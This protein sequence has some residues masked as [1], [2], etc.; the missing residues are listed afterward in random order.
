M[1]HIIEG[2]KETL[3]ECEFKR[4]IYSSR[5]FESYREKLAEDIFNYVLSELEINAE[6]LRDSEQRGMCYE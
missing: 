1:K 3:K 4:N 5:E 2:I 6:A